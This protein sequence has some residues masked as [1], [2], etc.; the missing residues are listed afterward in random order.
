MLLATLEGTYVQR[1]C[2]LVISIN[3]GKRALCYQATLI[4]N[5]LPVAQY[6]ATTVRQFSS[7][8][9]AVNYLVLLYLVV[10]LFCCK[11][12]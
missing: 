5:H 12:Y 9:C 7:L 4:W 6:D 10:V 11:V 8:F 2:V 3:Y 1:L